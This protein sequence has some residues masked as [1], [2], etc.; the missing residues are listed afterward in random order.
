MLWRRHSGLGAGKWKARRVIV[1]DCMK[2]EGGGTREGGCV[3]GVW[4]G[5]GRLEGWWV[6]VGYGGGIKGWVLETGRRSPSISESLASRVIV[7]IGYRF[8]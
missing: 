2:G 6:E 7:G 4:C 5:G 8:G 1:G 3:G